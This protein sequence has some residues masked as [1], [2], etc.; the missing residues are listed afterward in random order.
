[1]NVLKRYITL[2]TLLITTL[3]I[4]SCGDRLSQNKLKT[5]D[6]ESHTYYKNGVELHKA[7]DFL[8][9]AEAL[10][11]ASRIQKLRLSLEN[12]PS[13]DDFHY[14]AQVYEKLGDV[15]SDVN[16]LRPASYFYDEALN[17]FENANRHYEVIEMLLKIGDLYQY[18]HIPNIAL[19]NYETAE[20]KK[21]LTE[22]QVDIIL[23]KKGIALYDVFDI[24]TADSIYRRIST[25]SQ[26]SIDYKYFTACHFYNKN[27]YKEALPYLLQCFDNGNQN[28]KIAAAEMLASVCFSLNRQEQ[29]LEYAQFQAKAQSAEARLTPT[30]VEMESLYEQYLIDINSQMPENTGKMRNF[31][32]ILTII[33]IVL[34]IGVVALYLIFNRHRK[35]KEQIID[36][37]S[38][39][40]E[41]AAIVEQETHSFEDNYNDFISTNI[42]KDIKASL[43]GKQI[44]IKTVGDYPRLALTK[45]KLIA[46][47]TQFNES[48]PNLTHSLSELYPD[49]TPADFRFIILS[50]MGFSDMEIAVLLK[51]TYGSANKRSNRIKDII[52]TEEELEHFIPNLLRT[53]RY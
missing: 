35:D 16:S 21:N 14:L 9:S 44:F 47:T 48:F 8:H 37:I 17:Q 28:M 15:Y 19:I 50:L 7:S 53:V 12:S 25:K 40:L 26:Q 10:L 20:A 32:L 43:E 34:I 2:I 11:E 13:N 3:C 29:E 46:L 33:V 49:L 18:N 36:N 27:N 31:I 45:N 52:H 23:T 6:E 30:R 24:E 51:Q 42:Y 1:M 39:K 38:K 5:L 22:Q 41:E 4:T